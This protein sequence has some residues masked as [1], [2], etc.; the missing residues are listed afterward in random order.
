MKKKINL[1][2]TQI[3]EALSKL[4]FLKS[5]SFLILP[6]AIILVAALLYIF[7]PV[8]N[9]KL[10]AKIEKE[11]VKNG[12]I[13]SSLS[14]DVVSK[15]QWEQEEKAGIA[16]LA[17]LENIAKLA[18][19]S[20]QRNLLSYDVFPEPVESSPIIFKQFGQKFQSH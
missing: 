13:L 15:N 18:L 10:Q 12:K 3:K 11:S 14:K 9:G 6:S 20:T 1:D 19:Q 8:M 5:Y 2:M 4:T 7:I 16:Y 17:D